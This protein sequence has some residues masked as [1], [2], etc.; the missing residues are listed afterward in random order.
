MYIAPQKIDG[1]DWEWGNGLALDFNAKEFSTNSNKLS[2]GGDINTG[3]NLTIG[4]DKVI[5]GPGRLH[6]N[7]DELLYL[8]N[9]AGVI[10]GKEWGGNGNLRVQGNYYAEG[11]A[12]PILTKV[13]TGG[14]A[15]DIDTGV[16]HEQYPAVSMGGFYSSLDLEER[17]GG[18]FEFNTFKRDGK[19][20]IFFNPR[21]QGNWHG[22][23]KNVR[24]RLTFFHKSMVQDDSPNWWGLHI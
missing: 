3:G 13:V 2:V 9:K 20:W 6:I 19:W 22:G 15:R 14:L 11:D 1:T 18:S 10:I 8:L 24:A 21:A 16:N 12:R 7:G 4:K 23:E 5:T 17:D